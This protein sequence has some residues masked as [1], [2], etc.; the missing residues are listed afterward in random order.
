M[1][2]VKFCPFPDCGNVIDARD[3]DLVEQKKLFVKC[4][5]GTGVGVISDSTTIV[6]G[7][8]LVTLISRVV[9]YSRRAGYPGV[10]AVVSLSMGTRSPYKTTTA[11]KPRV[12]SEYPGRGRP[13]SD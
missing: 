12:L 3:V 2:Q 5:C 4:L 10:Q 13:P 8:L 9:P 1:E 6:A 11:R 7:V